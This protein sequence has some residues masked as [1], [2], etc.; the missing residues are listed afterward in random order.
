MSRAFFL[1]PDWTFSNWQNAKTAFTGG[2]GGSAARAFWLRSAV[3]GVGLTQLTSLLLSGKKSDDPTQVYLGQDHHGNDVYQNL[4]FAGAP[5]DMI[6][7]VKNVQDYGALQGT[8]HSVAAKLA[9][10]TRTGV[11]VLTNRNWMGQEIAKRGSGE[12]G[13]IR[14][15][16]HVASQLLPV[17]FSATN[18]VQMEAS[19][20]A[21]GQHPA[22]DQV[23]RIARLLGDATKDYTP[24]EFLSTF[25][26]GTKPRHVP[27][28]KQVRAQRK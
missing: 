11:Q 17:P 4:F 15:A 26:G 9:P 16:A 21:S 10:I 1:A 23:K 5:S 6:G 27:H 22:P 14:T 3:V 13:D 25:A 19:N 12:Q 8:A 24:T 20:I 18:L 7:L 2:P 28:W